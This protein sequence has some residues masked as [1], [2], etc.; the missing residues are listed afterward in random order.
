MAF[1]EPKPESN[2]PVKLFRFGAVA[3]SV[4]KKTHEGKTYYSATASRAFTRDDGDN[5]EYSTQ[6]D[7]SDLPIVAR[8]LDMAFAWI[9]TQGGK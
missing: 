8:L 9:V 2:P 5:W 4:W 3:V 1:K 6:Y 7:A